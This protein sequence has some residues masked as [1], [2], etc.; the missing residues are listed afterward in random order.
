MFLTSTF[1][2]LPLS[3]SSIRL[4][5]G[6]RHWLLASLA[7]L[8]LAAG[9]L[10]TAVTPAA[11]ASKGMGTWTMVTRATSC[12]SWLDS[13]NRPFQQ[14]VYAA[15]PRILG[16]IPSS[17]AQHW[18]LLQWRLAGTT[19]WVDLETRSSV[20]TATQLFN[21]QPEVTFP[22]QKWT[23]STGVL[24]RYEFRTKHWVAFLDGSGR[25]IAGTGTG[26]IVADAYATQL[27]KD[28]QSVSSSSAFGCVI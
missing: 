19:T 25:A 27:W 15:S 7:A 2:V 4:G 3:R 26:W 20:A 1:H 5:R 8:M 22:N 16:T 18:V 10:G 28:S 24:G 11:A 6:P 9:Y 13:S 12:T 21:T 14:W 17:R 23:F